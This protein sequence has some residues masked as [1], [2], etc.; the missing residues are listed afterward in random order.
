[1]DVKLI[2]EFDVPNRAPVAN[3]DNYTMAEDQILVSG[4]LANDTDADGN[5][6]SAI[7][8]S[9]PHHGALTLNAN[10]LFTYAPAANYNGSDS[11][12]YKANDGT[13]DSNVATVVINVTSVNDA[14][15]G[16]DNTVT[17]P[18]DTA[19]VFKVAD[20]PFTDPNDSPANALAA[21]KIN[22]LP[23]AA[24]G[25]LTDNGIAVTAGQSVSIAD[26]IGSKLMFTPAANA[27]GSPS[28]TFQVQDDGGIANGGVD[29][30]Q[31]PNTM[32][33]NVTP[34][35][36][37]PVANNDN[38]TMAEDQILVSGV[39]ANDTDAD[40]NPLSAILLSGPHHGA[41]TLNANGLFT[42]APVANYNGSDSFT[43]KANDG[44]ADSNVAT[45][46]INVTSVNDAPVG[47]DNTV[48]TPEDTAYVFKVADFPFTDPNDS[49]ANA[50]AAV[51]ISTLPSA[52]AGTLTDNG[53]A[54]T[55]GQSVSIA[56]IIGSKLIFTPAANANGSPSFTF[57]VQ[58]DGGIA[59]GGVDL[60]QLPNTVTINVTPVNHAPVAINDS[61]TTA[62]NT[63][64]TVS[65]T[66][67]LNNDIDVDGNPLS[68]ILVSGTAHGALTLN[69]DGSFTYTPAANY[70]GSDS[71]TYK[72]NDGTADS[73]VATADITVPSVNAAPVFDSG[74]TATIAEKL[75]TQTVVYDAHATDAENDTLTYSLPTGV[76]D[77]DLFNINAST[78]EVT[79]KTSPNF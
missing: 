73:N 3:N 1:G 55:A 64:L 40:G 16:A 51:K 46:V 50:L 26:I 54:V 5:P 23:S 68:A 14:P 11:F 19:Y 52:A 22:T 36:H 20:S 9:G 53:F 37:A 59:N 72:V 7:L 6:L 30:A 25:T 65:A 33:I 39:L 48:T 8:V 34:V 58:D 41:L 15:V 47:A 31:V 63:T 35:N 42:Y 43:Y 60:A 71:F 66:S 38:Y 75:I 45:V 21:V 77:N 44:T 4:V 2:G 79:F 17:T 78:G 27:N 24:A 69:A 74:G 13:A 29:L 10:G 57:Q 67:V 70:I 49:P 32:T 28:F 18:E 12:T 56:D 62:E 76:V 61:Y